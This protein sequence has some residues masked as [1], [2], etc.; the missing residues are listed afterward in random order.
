MSGAPSA[1]EI[2]T[3][4]ATILECAEVTGLLEEG[5]ELGCLSNQDVTEALRDV[6]LTAVQLEELLHILADAGIELIEE[7]AP[8]GEGATSEPADDELRT[9]EPEVMK[10]MSSDSVHLYLRELGRAP[11]LTGAEEVSLARRIERGDEVARRRLIESNLRLVVSI[12]KRHGG[13]GLP[14]L[15]LIQEGNLG[16]MRAVEKFDYRRGFKFSTYA[17]W[18][19]RQAVSRALA[20]QSRT[21]R[22]PVHMTEKIQAYVRVQRMLLQDMGHE[23]TIE[24]IAAGMEVTTDKAREIRRISQEPASLQQQIGDDDGAQLIDF[25]EDTQAVAPVDAV[26]DLAQREQILAVLSALPPRESSVLRLRFGLDD[27]RP[28]TLDQVGRVFGVTR[29]R[30]RQIEARTL[31]QLKSG[32]AAQCLREYLD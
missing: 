7:D 29:E 3:L 14:L 8:A 18:W 28:R 9:H 22:V 16:L 10:V 19:I 11:L 23:P 17:T 4:E 27:G 1:D 5:R 30:I 15:D 13:R 12:A 32:Q 26:T 31:A 2:D 24:E 25:L 21:I 6:E 20:D